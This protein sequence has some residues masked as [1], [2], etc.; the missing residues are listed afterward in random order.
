MIEY[1]TGDL[2]AEKADALVNAVNCVRKTWPENFRVYTVACRN[3]QVHPGRMFTFETCQLAPPRYIIDFPTKRHWRSSLRLE[4]IDAGLGTLVAEIR[5][6]GDAAQ[7]VRGEGA[8]FGADGLEFMAGAG[9]ATP[10]SAAGRRRP[11]GRPATQARWRRGPSPERRR[12]PA[13]VPRAGPLPGPARRVRP[14]WI[15][16]SGKERSTR[17]VNGSS[18]PGQV[19][20]GV[21]RARWTVAGYTRWPVSRVADSRSERTVLHQPVDLIG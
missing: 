11:A 16:P 19:Q 14:R 4:D 21:R 17:P 9:H 2:L 18:R 13:R 20:R 10:A 7:E 12:A 3:A 1:K 15:A 6:L 8:A 5:H